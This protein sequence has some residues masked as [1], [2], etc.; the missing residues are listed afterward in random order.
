MKVLRLFLLMSALA[1]VLAACGGTD[2]EKTTQKEQPAETS[3]EA[4]TTTN[5]S[6]DVEEFTINATNWDFTSDKELVVKKGTNVKLNLVNEEGVHTISN[7]ELGIDLKVDT[8]AE[9]KADTTGE[10]ELICST[11][12]GATEDHEAMKI[13]LKVVD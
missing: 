4:D 10:F 6:S 12:C 7:E 9:F 2:E 3:T 1:I 13:S 8:P 11:I 5:T